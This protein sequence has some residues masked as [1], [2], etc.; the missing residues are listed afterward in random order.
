MIKSY[1][2]ETNLSP[3]ECVSFWKN[4]LGSWHCRFHVLSKRRKFKTW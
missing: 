3:Q 1:C 4:R 2:D